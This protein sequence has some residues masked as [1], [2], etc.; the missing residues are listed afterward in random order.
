MDSGSGNLQP[1]KNGCLDQVQEEGEKDGAGEGATDDPN[2]QGLHRDAAN[3]QRGDNHDVG[4]R[5][6]NDPGAGPGTPQVPAF[7]KG[8]EHGLAA[9]YQDDHGEGLERGEVEA[10]PELAQEQRT[11]AKPEKT[12]PREG[13]GQGQLPDSPPVWPG[14]L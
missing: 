12:G 5:G 1:A 8:I 13:A 11:G 10:K 2:G 3:G 14:R 6:D 4:S 9:E 7:A